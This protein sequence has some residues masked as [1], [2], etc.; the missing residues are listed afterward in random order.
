MIMI[1]RRYGGVAS[2]AA[3][4]A[5]APALV[6]PARAAQ[7][8]SPELQRLVEAEFTSG[9]PSYCK[10]YMSGYDCSCFAKKVHAYRLDEFAREG[11]KMLVQPHSATS[12]TKIFDQPLNNLVG[13][14]LV[15][16]RQCARQ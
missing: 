15:D 3:I 16:Y 2:L 6:T 14:N 11:E 9:A 8:M 7:Q 5:A 4:L 1:S 13:A 12:N 10:K